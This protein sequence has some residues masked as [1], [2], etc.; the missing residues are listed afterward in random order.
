M[1]SRL[2]LIKTCQKFRDRRDAC[3]ATWV[4]ALRRRG[5]ACYF[6]EGGHAVP[7]IDNSDR[8]I[9][10]AGSDD[11]NS[12]SIKLRDGLRLLLDNDLPFKHVF[13][14]D[15]NTFVH[16]RRWEAFI[17]KS[18]FV[19]LNTAKIPWVHGG[20]GWYMSRHCCQLY[21]ARTRKRFSG[22]D[23]LVSD[24][25]RRE[26]IVLDSRP[27]LFSFQHDRVCACNQLITCH[28]V[29]P[30]EMRELFWKTYEI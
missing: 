29:D 6:L 4:E 17:P 1:D 24:I 23:V 20:A 15:D 21:V 2:V 28:Y 7:G 13:I 11:Y 25:L 30:P 14:A 5:I 12:N 19:G 22:D 27:E 26:G 10:I 8:V 16:A 18:E 9:Q 3:E